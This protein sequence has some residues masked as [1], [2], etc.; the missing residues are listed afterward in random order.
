MIE[1]GRLI[2]PG[3]IVQKLVAFW[4]CMEVVTRHV[5]IDERDLRSRWR[6]GKEAVRRKKKARKTSL[7]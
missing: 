3:A 7:F 5:R 4:E 1:A 2:G 6:A